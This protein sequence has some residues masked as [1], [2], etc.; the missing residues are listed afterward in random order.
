MSEQQTQFELDTVDIINAAKIMEA[1]INAGAFSVE[2]LVKVAPVVDRF[3]K[4]SNAVIEEH[5]KQVEAASD[6]VDGTNVQDDT[7]E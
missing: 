3:I 6:E 7:N 5:N 2:D 1:A 4:F